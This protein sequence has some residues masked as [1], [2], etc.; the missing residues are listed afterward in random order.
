[1]A[2]KTLIVA[3]NVWVSKGG[4]SKP[5]KSKMGWW[6]WFVGHGKNWWNWEKHDVDKTGKSSFVEKEGQ[7]VKGHK[8]EQIDVEEEE[9]VRELKG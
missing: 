6:W 5:T 2:V 1:M 4:E 7:H 8:D 9:E 3:R